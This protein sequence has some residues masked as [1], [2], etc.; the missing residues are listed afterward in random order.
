MDGSWSSVRKCEFQTSLWSSRE[1][2]ARKQRM[3]GSKWV[4]HSIKVDW[5]LSWAGL[6]PAPVV[7]SQWSEWSFQNLTQSRSLLCSAAPQ[8]LLI[9]SFS[10]NGFLSPLTLPLAHC[11]HTEL[12]TVCGTPRPPSH[13]HAFCSMSIILW[14]QN[15]IVQDGISVWPL[16]WDRAKCPWLRMAF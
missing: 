3:C 2:W 7:W 1:H 5:E 11:R 12:P 9:F 8:W 6:W 10:P 15:Y 16:Q 13:L 4:L 14:F